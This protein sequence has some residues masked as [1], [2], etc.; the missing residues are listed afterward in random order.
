[1]KLEVATPCPLPA[2]G[3]DQSADLPWTTTW[4]LLNP[5]STQDQDLDVLDPGLEPG[6]DR[7]FPHSGPTLVTEVH[8]D[9]PRP[10]PF[11][12]S[13]GVHPR[14]IW[15]SLESGRL[16]LVRSENLA[17]VLPVFPFLTYSQAIRHDFAD[18][19]TNPLS[20]RIRCRDVDHT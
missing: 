1:M 13:S 11:F 2:H 3:A 5:D 19:F 6:P 20:L 15:T 18:E 12:E 7:K 14:W 8:F 4:T 10:S 17:I 16:M 9:P